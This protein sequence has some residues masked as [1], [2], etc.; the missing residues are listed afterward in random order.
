MSVSSV[1]TVD[2]VCLMNNDNNVCIQCSNTRCSV[3]LMNNDNNVCI[4]CSN[5][6]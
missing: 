2:S 1:Q 6:R 3:C 5:S 4:Q